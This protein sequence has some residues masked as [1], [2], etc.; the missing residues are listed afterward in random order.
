MKL[1]YIVV[2]DAYN[3][4]SDSRITNIEEMSLHI[5]TFFLNLSSQDVSVLRFADTDS[6]TQTYKK[7]KMYRDC[8]FWAFFVVGEPTNESNFFWCDAFFSHTKNTKTKY[9]S[10]GD[11]SW[12]KKLV[13]VPIKKYKELWDQFENI[14]S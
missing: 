5:L 9:L 10:N 13:D 3:N 7:L 2:D 1:R 14:K 12:V 11:I 4:K 6:S 8:Q